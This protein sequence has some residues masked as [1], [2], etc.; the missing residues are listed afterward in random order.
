MAPAGVVPDVDAH[1]AVRS[2]GLLDDRERVGG[3]DDVGERQELE[4]HDRAVIGGAIA[5]GTEA[6]RGVGDRS[7]ERP[8]RLHVPALERVDQL[9]HHRFEVP[10][11]VGRCRCAPPG[12]HLD[13]GEA[14]VGG[15]EQIAQLG[16]REP[17]VAHLDELPGEEPD[18]GEPGGA[19]GTDAIVER[20]VAIEAEVAEHQVVGVQHARSDH[21]TTLAV[22]Q[23]GVERAEL[24]FGRPRIG[25]EQ[26]LQRDA[27]DQ[28]DQS[29][30][31]G[32]GVVDA[33]HRREQLDQI[34]P[35][36]PVQLALGGGEAVVARCRAGQRDG[37]DPVDPRVVVGRQRAL[38]RCPQR[39]GGGLLAARRSAGT[40]LLDRRAQRE[41]EQFVLVGEVVHEGAGGPPGLGRDLTHRGAVDT[42][43]CDHPG[44]GRREFRPSLVDVDD[45]RH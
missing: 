17:G 34:A 29:L 26:R 15:V 10:V 20:V 11:R 45:L 16:D 31:F 8:D 42:G 5:H 22:Q 35:V 40:A 43:A 30:G 36:P 3:V 28:P 2:V 21:R 7:L 25:I 13:L 14:H 33:G 37:H 4:S 18:A 6:A 23:A 9:P 24:A 32:R 38:E 12:E 27:V 19:G 41:V 39:V 44:G 1:A